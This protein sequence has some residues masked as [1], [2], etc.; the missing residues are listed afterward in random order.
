ML[1]CIKHCDSSNAVILFKLVGNEC[2]VNIKCS[3]FVPLVVGI[4]S[5][6]W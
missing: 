6:T 4:A 3:Q 1:H 5:E 2:Y